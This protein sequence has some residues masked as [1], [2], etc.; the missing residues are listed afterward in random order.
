MES[1]IQNDKMLALREKLLSVEED[2]AQGRSGCTIDE[3]NNYLE[4][5]IESVAKPPP[6]GMGI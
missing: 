1:C 3:L 6:L 2:R 5:I 4:A